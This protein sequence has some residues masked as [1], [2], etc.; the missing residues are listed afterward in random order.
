MAKKPLYK[1]AYELSDKYKERGI[2]YVYNQRNRTVYLSVLA[3]PTFV[4][5]VDY[6]Q[7][8]GHLPI[9]GDVLDT[10]DID[11]W[12]ERVKREYANRWKDNEVLLKFLDTVH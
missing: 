4:P 1:I 11:Y 8:V 2:R 7:A 9:S 3:A 10:L 12:V 6:C 5:D